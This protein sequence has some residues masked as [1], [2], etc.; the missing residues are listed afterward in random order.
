[1]RPPGAPGRRSRRARRAGGDGAARRAGV[2][3]AGPAAPASSRAP[4]LAGYLCA[5]AAGATWGTTGPLSTGLYRLMPATSIGFWRVLLGPVCL[6]L[7]GLLFRR[8]LFRVDPRGWLLV[9]A[10]GGCRVAPFEVAYQFALAGAGLA[11]RGRSGRGS[12]A[13]GEFPV[14]R[15]GP[16]DRGRT[17]GGRRDDRAGRRHPA[18][19]V[20]V[21]PTAQRAR[22]A[23]TGAGRGWSRRRLPPGSERGRSLMLTAALMVVALQQPAPATAPAP[24]AAAAL[25]PQVGD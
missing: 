1:R 12:G 6:A 24:G 9:G 17:G 5:L 11:R 25:P 20:T 8:A 23:R 16:A 14:L 7:L 3:A 10:G 2:A 15:R 13:R 4:R 18:R 22:L 21:Q 19:P